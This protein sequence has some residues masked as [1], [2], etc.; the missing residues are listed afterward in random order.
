MAAMSMGRPDFRTIILC[1]SLVCFCPSG[2]STDLLFWSESPTAAK[3]SDFAFGCYATGPLKAETIRFGSKVKIQGRRT[4]NEY[5]SDSN[6][7]PNGNRTLNS[8]SGFPSGSVIA[9]STQDSYTF[10]RIVMPKRKVGR[11]G[12]FYCKV[13]KEVITVINPVESEADIVPQYYGRTI[14]INDGS[15]IL[16]V[17]KISDENKEVQ[18]RHNNE[19]IKKW[20][21]DTGVTLDGNAMDAGLYEIRLKKKY[22]DTQGFMQLYVRGCGAGKWDENCGENCRECHNGGMCDDTNGRC[23]CAPGFMGDNCETACPVGYFGPSCEIPCSSGS[24]HEPTCQGQYV[25]QKSPFGCSCVAGYGGK[26]CTTECQSR[27]FGAGCT[28]KCNF[29]VG[30]KCNRFTGN[31]DEGCKDGKTEP[32]CTVPM[33]PPTTVQP[34][35]PQLVSAPNVDDVTATSMNVLWE[36]WNSQRDSGT[37]PVTEYRVC[38]RENGEEWVYESES[39]PTMMT[40]ISSLRP[41]TTYEIVVEA[42]GHLSGDPCDL[43]SPSKRIQTKCGKPTISPSIRNVRAKG[44]RSLKVTWQVDDITEET[45]RCSVESALCIIYYSVAGSDSRTTSTLN[46]T[47]TDGEVTI[48][49]LEPCTNYEVELAVWN[50]VKEGSRSQPRTGETTAPEPKG[51]RDLDIEVYNTESPTELLITWARPQKCAWLYHH[52]VKYKVLNRDMCRE[53]DH[54]FTLAD[55]TTRGFEGNYTLRGLYPNTRYKVEV[56]TILGE[57][58]DSWG[59]REHTTRKTAPSGAPEN[60]VSVAVKSTQANFSWN[61]PQCGSRNGDISEYY[62]QI[63]KLKGA[64]KRKSQSLTIDDT[65]VSFSGLV[66]YSDYEFQVKAK[67]KIDY[68]PYSEPVKI[69]TPEDYPGPPTNLSIKSK[70]NSSVTLQWGIPTKPNGRIISY[71]VEWQNIDGVRTSNVTELTENLEET[72]I[73]EVKNLDS[74][75]RYIFYV[76]ALTSVGRGKMAH[77][78]SVE[79]DVGVPGQPINLEAKGKTQT[80]IT[81]TW[82]KPAQPAQAKVITKYQIHIESTESLNPNVVLKPYEEN[83]VESGKT[84]YTIPDLVASTKYKISVRAFTVAGPGGWSKAIMVNTKI[85]VPD[86]SEIPPPVIVGRVTDSTLK[87]E[88]HSVQ[89]DTAF[90]SAFK[91]LVNKTDTNRRKRDVSNDGWRMVDYQ[92]AMA[93]GLPYYVTAEFS[94]NQTLPE[95]FIVGDGKIYRGYYNAPLEAY[96]QY[97]LHL[98]LVSTTPEETQIVLS[99]GSEMIPVSSSEK[100]ISPIMLA[101]IVGVALVV[102]AIVIAACIIVRYQRE[103]KKTP[104]VVENGRAPIYKPPKDRRPMYI[105]TPTGNVDVH[106]LEELKPQ[107]GGDLGIKLRD[108]A[109]Y[110]KNRRANSFQGFVEE[111]ESL[112]QGPTMPHSHSIKADNQMKNRY[113]NIVAYDHSRVVLD[114][115][116]DDPSSDYINANYIDGYKRMNAFIASQG[117]NEDTTP[118]FWRMIWQENTEVIIMATNIVERGKTK[119]AEYWPEK[120]EQYGAITVCFEAVER[121]ADFII[122][123]F[124]IQ[125]EGSKECRIVKQFHFTVWPD[126]GVP[127]YATAVLAFLKRVKASITPGTGPIVVHCSAGVGRTGTFIVIDSMMDMMKSEGQVDIYNFVKRIRSQRIN[128][129]QTLDQYVFIYE[130]VLEA[131]LCGDTSITTSDYR[132]RLYRMKQINSRTN[133]N[134]IFQEF[135]NLSVVCPQ[136]EPDDCDDGHL[137]ENLDK[138]RFPNIIPVDRCRP[139]LMTFVEG[140]TDYINASFVD[141]YK[142]KDAFLATQMPLP[143]TIVDFWRLLYDYK[144][145]SVVMLNAMDPTDETLGKYWPEEESMEYGPF[146]VEV[147]SSSHYGSII[148]RVFR[149]YLTEGK[150]SDPVRMIQQFH[151]TCWPMGHDVPQS[152]PAVIDLISLVEKWQQQTGNGPITV[153][154]LNGLGRSGTLCAIYATIERMKVEQMIDVF[155]AVKKLRLNRPNMVQNLEQYGFCYDAA[156]EFLDSFDTYANFK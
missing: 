126:M 82:H 17:S 78:N 47:F 64:E 141:G 5:V 155:Q 58:R 80:S 112:P 108:L 40:T 81:I 45:L 37:G 54:E 46:S 29:C 116:P 144:S 121:L 130:A 139:Y 146:T 12:A 105:K 21:G 50:G 39:Q 138:N 32:Q 119:C 28:K 30:K 24:G 117:P 56:S 86:K 140:S 87:V 102:L 34:Q 90:I 148:C 41:Y 73:Y 6:D 109:E 136:P 106:E 2:I 13:D 118:D 129:V 19:H 42:V 22:N 70:T 134:M 145:C 43:T 120:K 69:T 93:Q 75:T 18:W 124:R 156:M 115:L 111:Y 61:Q 15:F 8:D 128:M 72:M 151:L 95:T 63:V 132:I 143:N 79:T 101:A 142:R 10:H 65:V 135:Q 67:N 57:Q 96:A 35:P 114:P 36:P 100:E 133:Q 110:I 27:M 153:H 147:A 103:M 94:G 91:L 26:D 113:I 48:N 68:G 131:S 16:N 25:C 38:Y 62:A 9:V 88:L 123:I 23:I 52:E 89:S 149:L 125:M 53:E 66:P 84:E 7:T 11:T 60:V 76:A 59:K 74:S 150:D 98:V 97:Q 99:Q 20:N 71:R 152:K 154:C 3:N 127:M 4:I 33:E 14:N 122:R 77:S 83:F 107:V 31:C 85:K 137:P 49:G 55:N 44:S 104:A 92:T 51:S 1:F